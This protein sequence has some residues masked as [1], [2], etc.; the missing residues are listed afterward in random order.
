MVLG[1]V[2][3]ALEVVHVDCG[4]TPR[5]EASGDN[6][7]DGEVDAGAKPML[8]LEGERL[9]DLCRVSALLIGLNSQRSGLQ[10]R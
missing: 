5:S 3:N 6:D 9:Q 4:A 10:Q 1:D 2:K 8:L 7:G